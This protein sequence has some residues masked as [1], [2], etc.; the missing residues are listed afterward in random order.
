MANLKNG[1]RG[2]EVLDIQRQ[3]VLLGYSIKV[4]GIFGKE[5]E[6]AVRSF[7]SKSGIQIDG[8]VGPQTRAAIARA[9]GGTTSTNPST[10]TNPPATNSNPPTL[11]AGTGGDS[12]ELILIVLAIGLGLFLLPKILSGKKRRR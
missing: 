11:A 3:L 1:S 9:L 10:P 6:G 8:I 7:Q 5:T 4:D 2:Q 12:A